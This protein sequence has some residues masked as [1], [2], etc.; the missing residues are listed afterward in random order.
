MLHKLK[1][2]IQLRLLQ[3]ILAQTLE[4]QVYEVLVLY[5]KVPDA[6]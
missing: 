4:L 1:G 3:L 2:V 6:L 5:L